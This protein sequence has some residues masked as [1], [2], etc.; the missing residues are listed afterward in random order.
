M[1]NQKLTKVETATEIRPRL[2]AAVKVFG[3]RLLLTP[4]CGFAT[5]ADN[6]ISSSDIATAKLAALVKARAEVLGFDHHVG[7]ESG[8]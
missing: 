2:D 3:S 5:F 4:D 7:I 6:P 8:S 1:V